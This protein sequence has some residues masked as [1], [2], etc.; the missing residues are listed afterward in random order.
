MSVLL[1]I[2]GL[3]L[4]LGGANFMT[5]GAA[6]IARRLGMSEFMVGLTIVSMLT[7]APELVVSLTSAS[8]GAAP[9]AVGNIVGSNI[10]NILVIVGLTAVIKPVKIEGSLLVN[11]IPMVILSSIALLA[12]GCSPWLDGLMPTVTR[13]D[14]ILL[15]LFFLIFIRFTLA[16]ARKADLKEDPLSIEGESR[17][18]LSWVR[19]IIYLAAGLA[20]LIFGGDFFVAGATGIARAAGMSDA[21]I[22]LTIIAAGTS[23]PELATSV[24]AAMKGSPGICI[25]NAIGSNI[26]N[27]LFVL[28]LTST[29]LPL[30]LGNISLYDLTVMTGAAILF[31]CV[32]WFGGYR[33]IKRSEGILMLLL[34]IGYV[35]GLVLNAEI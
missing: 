25:G 16:Q 13:V 34:Y 4:I 19:S 24:V 7:S 15:L 10:F 27:I 3:I 1:F 17:P 33:T 30:P 6:A 20:A 29:I 35:T 22:G 5:D 23:L 28:G 11:E 9:M 21:M 32:G 14:G 12:I 2:G 8:R 18:T 26:F 31:W